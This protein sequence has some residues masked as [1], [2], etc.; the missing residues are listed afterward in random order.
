MK[1]KPLPRRKIVCGF[2]G[3]VFEAAHSL[4]RY[5]RRECQLQASKCRNGAA[6]PMLNIQAS[7][8]TVGAIAEL[9][10]V[11]ELLAAGYDVYRASSPACPCDLVVIKQGC[12][13]RIEVTSV[14][15][16]LYKEPTMPAR[17][18]SY[19]HWDIV[20]VYVR[21]TD[22]ILYF[23]ALPAFPNKS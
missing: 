10:V 4:R 15:G 13:L 9:K 17:K 19:S 3:D 5:C 2:C 1:G 22:E 16:N 6:T 7:G 21:S 11:V 23:P 14:V 18:N 8:T 20:A 12:V